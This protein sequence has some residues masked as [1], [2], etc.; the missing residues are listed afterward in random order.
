[1]R[2]R[3][4]DELWAL[5][6]PGSRP[7]ALQDLRMPARN[8]VRFGRPGCIIPSTPIVGS[9]N[10]LGEAM[11]SIARL[12]VLGGFLALV[13]SS[14]ALAACGIG[15]TI[16]E[17]N[18]GTGAKLLAFTT[19]VWTLKAISTTSE[20]SGCTAKNNLFKR[21][22]LDA[23]IHDYASQNL[24][25]LAADMARGRGEHVDVFAHLLEL[26]D[27]HS[28]AFRS[29]VQ[30]NFETLFP[31]DHVTAGEMLGALRRLMVGNDL[32]SEYVTS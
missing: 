15:S 29:L 26:S 1:M 19:N 16:W 4:R 13:P 27:E 31:H 32:L 20:I 25:H 10:Q 11:K 14:T 2:L 22:S 6:P 17:G 24:D 21:A 23:K 3:V 7:G 12:I 9:S 28:D 8:P 30:R 5:L 18:D